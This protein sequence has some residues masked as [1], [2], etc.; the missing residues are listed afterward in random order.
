MEQNVINVQQ[1]IIWQ[2][3][4][5]KKNSLWEKLTRTGIFKRETIEKKCLSVRMLKYTMSQCMHVEIYHVS[6]HAC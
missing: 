1:Q 4:I 5:C 2:Q 3:N 6:V